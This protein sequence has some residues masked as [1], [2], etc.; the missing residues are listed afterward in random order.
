MQ[1]WDSS[2]LLPLVLRQP[3]F[4]NRC[5]RA[6]RRDVPRVVAFLARIEC[7]SAVERLG[8]AGGLNA[9]ARRRS[10]MRIDKLLAAFDIVVFSGDVEAHA[11]TLLSRHA[12]R[13]L[14]ALQ[15]GC[16]L[17]LTPHGDSDLR[18]DLVCCDRRLATAAAAEGFSLVVPL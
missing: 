3:P 1:F 6:F 15:L 2:A 17:S 4:S 8:R 7:R 12:L 9:A 18:P 14:D 5:R 10:L 13:S 16:A 11:L